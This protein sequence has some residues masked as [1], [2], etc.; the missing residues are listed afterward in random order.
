MHFCHVGITIVV[1]MLLCLINNL[2]DGVCTVN[3]NI[4]CANVS[5]YICTAYSLP[6][7]ILCPII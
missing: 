7:P 6:P 2:P 1:C 4:E 5:N 3:Q